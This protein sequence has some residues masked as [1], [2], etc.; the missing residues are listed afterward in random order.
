MNPSI[1]SILYSIHFF[2]VSESIPII[3]E[4][5]SFPRIPEAIDVE[6]S[7]FSPMKFS[8][9]VFNYSIL[10]YV[11]YNFYGIPPAI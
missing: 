5:S 11:S 2:L 4:A 1:M 9:I 8:Q 6:G 7:D 10:A 3:N